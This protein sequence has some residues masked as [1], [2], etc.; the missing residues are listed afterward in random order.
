MVVL[1][2]SIVTSGGG[3]KR[4]I[5]QSPQVVR[6]AWDSLSDVSWTLRYRP[7][8]LLAEDSIGMPALVDHGQPLILSG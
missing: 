7:C 3:M 6:G 4:D 5:C 2:G 8:K 1:F